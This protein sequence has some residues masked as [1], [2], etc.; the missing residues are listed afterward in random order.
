MMYLSFAD[1]DGK[2][3]FNSFKDGFF[4]FFSIILNEVS[5]CS[6][7]GTYLEIL[8]F[9]DKLLKKCLTILSSIEWKVTTA[10][11]PSSFY[12]LAADISP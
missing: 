4:G 6:S 2:F 9:S 12:I 1:L 5:G 3:S 8:L 7:L 11:T 10:K